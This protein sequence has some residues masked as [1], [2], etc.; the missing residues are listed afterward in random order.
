MAQFD[1]NINL[2]VNNREALKGVTQVEGGINKLIKGVKEFER[3]FNEALNPKAAVQS[4]FQLEQEQK[5]LRVFQQQNAALQNQ[6]RLA[7]QL[8]SAYDKLQVKVVGTELRRLE[9]ART[10][11]KALPGAGFSGQ[12]ALPAAGKTGGDA[13]SSPFLEAQR[14][15]AAIDKL[16][17]ETVK[18]KARKNKSLIR[19]ADAAEK[20]ARAAEGEVSRVT[21]NSS[22]W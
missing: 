16:N 2:N 20:I 9:R 18:E 5:A 22:S 8:G 7:A 1:A 17:A 6:V 13:T 15:A 3:V 14:A 12:R 11:Q 19:T 10:S 4:R 21:R